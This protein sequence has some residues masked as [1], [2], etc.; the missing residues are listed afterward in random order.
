MKTDDLIAHLAADAG[1]VRRHTALR[2]LGLGLS[3]GALAA[4][5]FTA[6]VLGLRRD[7]AA[8][9]H[10]WQFWAKF[11][12]PLALA[13]L[14]F[15]VVKQL[16]HP[17]LGTRPWQLLAP[18]LALALG[19]LWQWHA[20]PVDQHH[21]LL[22]GHSALVCPWLIALVALP[23]FAGTIWAMR[24]LAPTHPSTAGAAAGL[25]SGAAAAWIYAFHCN[26]TSLVFVA[27]WY[28]AGIALTTALGMIAGRWTLRW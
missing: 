15:P 25:L 26:E 27:V 4:F 10:D 16:S 11:A 20:T 3:G 21:H 7:L 23:L 9:S 19:A 17:G 1:A 22:F 13:A 6:I 14:A 5:V 8:A 24:R 2:L 18:V 28:T 12:Y